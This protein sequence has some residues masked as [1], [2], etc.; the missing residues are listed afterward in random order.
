MTSMGAAHRGNLRRMMRCIEPVVNRGAYRSA[1]DR[2]LARAVMAGD[3]EHDPLAPRDRL[4]E[5]AVNRLPGSIEAH[6]VKVDDA[7]GFDG[8]AAQP[9]VPA[10]VEGGPGT[11]TLRR[12][13]PN[14]RRVR[15]IP[16]WFR[17]NSYFNCLFG[18]FVTR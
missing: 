8:A 9:P 14:E 1:A 2:R 17:F 6:P 12:H 11:A 18:F 16:Y 4:L 10:A 7:V 15:C 3:Q 5:C 13:R